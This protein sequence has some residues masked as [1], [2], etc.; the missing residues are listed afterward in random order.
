MSGDTGRETPMNYCRSCHHVYASESQYG[1][2]TLVFEDC[3][4]CGSRDTGLAHH[5][6][7]KS[8]RRFSLL[9]NPQRD[10]YE[11][12]QYG[13][14]CRLVKGFSIMEGGEI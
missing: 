1:P 6:L 13:I 3:P 14:G 12:S 5:T 4:F 7:E 9:Q 8:G 10:A 2:L 11:Q